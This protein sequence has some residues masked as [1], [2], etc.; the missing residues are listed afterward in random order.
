VPKYFYDHVHLISSDPIKAAEFYEQGFGAKRV[1]L[2]RHADGATVIVLTLTGTKIIIRSPQ[3]NEARIPLDSPQKYFGLEH[4]GIMT[5]NLDEAV[6]N[7]KDM[8]V[9]F[10]QEIT[11]FLELSIA[12]VM[13]P[14]NVLVEIM[15][16]KEK[17][18]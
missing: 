12:Y 15:E 16:R 7:L 3:S 11:R 13:A 17:N 5:D 14:D 18:R 9:H 2:T 4:F 8:G 10:V 1:N 6:R